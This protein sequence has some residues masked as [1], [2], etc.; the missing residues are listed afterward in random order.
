MRQA[1]TTTGHVQDPTGRSFDLSL[2]TN[3]PDGLLSR[4]YAGGTFTGTY[5]FGR[6]LDDRVDE[7]LDMVGLVGECVD[8]APDCLRHL[9]DYPLHPVHEAPDRQTY[10]LYPCCHTEHFRGVVGCAATGLPAC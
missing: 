9:G 8:L 7:A 3:A 10:S 5:R 2:I 6:T 4:D 1:E